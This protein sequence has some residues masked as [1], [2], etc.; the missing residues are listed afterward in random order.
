MEP[1]IKCLSVPPLVVLGVKDHC[2]GPDQGGQMEDM[3]QS[4]ASGLSDLAVNTARGQVHERGVK[5]MGEA[6]LLQRIPQHA[7]IRIS[8]RIQSSRVPVYL[9]M[10]PPGDDLILT[11]DEDIVGNGNV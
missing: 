4:L 8:A 9:R 7:H 2:L 1:E 3:L 6:S 11:L 10:Y 5:G